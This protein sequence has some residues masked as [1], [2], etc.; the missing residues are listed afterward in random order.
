MAAKERIG[1]ID[2][3]RGAILVLILVDHIPGNLLDT[4]TPRNFGFSDSAEAFVFLSGLSVGVVYYRRTVTAGLVDVVRRC[5]GRAFRI[6]GVHLALTFCA[7][8]IF[9]AIYALSGLS[10]LIEAQGRGFVFTN[11]LR[12]LLGVVMLSQQLGYFNILPMYVVMM[13]WSPAILALARVSAPLAL[14]ASV[15]VYAAARL[16]GL[17]LPNWPE[18][19]SWFFNPFAWQLI[20]S[21]G[22][23]AAILWREN[24]APRS[25][26][27]LWISGLVVV[28]AAVIVTDGAGLAAGLRDAVFAHL[29]VQKQNLGLARLLHFLALAYLVA[30][31]PVLGRLADTVAG[32][33]V[34]R[35]GRHSLAI[36]A[37]GSLLSALGQALLRIADQPL[38]GGVAIFGVVYTLASIVG[39]FLLARYFEWH[40][41]SSAGWRREAAAGL[42]GD[43]LLSRLSARSLRS[44]FGH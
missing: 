27:L 17:D 28:L 11:P 41:S 16:F 10:D 4:I 22:V 25:T 38:G 26:P 33:E 14:T 8:G 3:W 44:P 5:F 13:L 15:G 40:P 42:D 7:I 32:R 9:G 31:T 6:Y 34:Q 37:S 35:L 20:F 1:A 30:Q 2:F 18:S 43:M 39:L 23:V 19:G 21:F 24:P 36:F 12:G 29:D